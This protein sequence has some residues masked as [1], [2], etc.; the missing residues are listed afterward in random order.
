MTDARTVKRRWAAACIRVLKARVYGRL[1]EASPMALERTAG[2]YS[3]AAAA[4]RQRWRDKL[5]RVSDGTRLALGQAPSSETSSVPRSSARPLRTSCILP[6]PRAP[7]RSPSRVRS[8][9]RIWETLTTLARGSPASPRRRGTFPGMAP[10]RRFDVT[11][12]TTVVEIALRL[13]RSCCTT[14]AGRRPAGA[15]PS[16]GPK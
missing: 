6:T 8:I 9:V 7:T 1:G 12:A 4:H 3:L 15:E 16:A 5:L 13:N 11:A 10:S 14:S 2:S